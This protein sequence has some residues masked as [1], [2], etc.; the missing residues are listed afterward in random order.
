M[1]AIWYISER[2]PIHQWT[3][4]PWWEARFHECNHDEQ[5]CNVDKAEHPDG[6]TKANLVQELT[7]H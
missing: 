5:A 3:C 6:P 4:L 7:H 2:L 1:Q